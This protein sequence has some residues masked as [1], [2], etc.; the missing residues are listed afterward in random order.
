MKKFL[1][2]ILFIACTPL[3]AQTDLP[4]EIL[5]ELQAAEANGGSRFYDELLNMFFMLG[6]LVALLYIGTWIFKRMTNTRMINI[7]ETSNIKVIESRAIS[8]KTSIYIVKA[9]GKTFA[10]GES[11]NGIV[12][13]GEVDGEN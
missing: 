12:N 13:L 4:P 1:I 5:K 2:A 7:N 9:Q 11:L 8:T 10:L 6:M 3:I